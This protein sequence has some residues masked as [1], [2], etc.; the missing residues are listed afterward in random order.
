MEIYAPLADRLGISQIKWELED[1]SLRYLDPEAYYSIVQLIDSK[2][3]ERDRIIQKTIEQLEAHVSDVVTGEFEIYGRPKHIY[4]IYRKMKDQNKDFSQIYDLLA[5]RVVVDSIKDCYA[6]LGI[7][8]TNWKPLPGRFKDY[9][10]MPKANLYQSLHTTILG[11]FGMPVEIQIRTFE[12]H[13]I[14]E[15][16]VA[17]HWA[18]K[19]GETEKV[20]D[21]PLQPQLDWFNQIEELQNESNDATDFMQSVKEDIFKDKVYVFTPRGDVTELPYGSVPLDFAYSIHSEVGNKTI[22][23]KVNGRIE[24]LNYQLKTGDIVEILTSKN[25]AGP[26]RD[27]VNLVTTSRAR[28]KIK[29]FFKLQ[30]RDENIEKGRQMVETAVHDLG[31][32]FK[33]LYTKETERHLL[34]RFNFASTEDLFAAVGFGEL[35][36]TAVANR[37]TDKVRR[38]KAEEQKKVPIEETLKEKS[39]ETEKVKSQNQKMTV[40]HKNGVVVEGADNLL[41]RLAHCCNPVP[42]DDIVGYITKGRGISIHRRDCNNVKNTDDSASRLIDVEWE[43]TAASDPDVNYD[44]EIELIAF[45]RSGLLN[46][47]LQVITPLTKQISTIN[48]NV[49]HDSSTVKIKLKLLIQNI[50]QLDKIIDKIKNIP[51]VYEVYRTLS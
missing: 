22:G 15:Y 23:A 39:E 48:G 42:G 50:S 35:S 25:S 10:A 28:N 9:I 32:S 30:D 51:D 36:T 4:S 43:D 27:W 11:D 13:E 47:V 21:N 45:E 24:P 6:V 37:M 49:S 40:R 7:I 8:H 5:I 19:M 34:E 46:E 44:V 1:I 18:Y 17:A 33:E 31:F 2:R 29:R 41:I 3:N 38:K 16:G 20:S 12:M 26:S 14:A